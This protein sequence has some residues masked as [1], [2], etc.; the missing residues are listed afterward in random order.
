MTKFFKRLNT[1]DTTHRDA[2][3]TVIAKCNDELTLWRGP[4]NR[5]Q[6]RTGMKT[7]RFRD[8]KSAFASWQEK[9]ELIRK[10]KRYEPNYTLR[11][12]GDRWVHSNIPDKRPS[13]LKTRKEMDWYVNR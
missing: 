9:Y 8:W 7:E 11:R 12:T 1:V 3:W 13:S 2:D 10:A 5:Y 6:V 4:N